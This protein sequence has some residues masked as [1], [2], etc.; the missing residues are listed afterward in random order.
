MAHAAHPDARWERGRHARRPRG[1]P[2]P[3][4]RDVLWRVKDR[5]S[6]DKLSMIAAGVAFYALMA[7]FPALIALVGVYGMLFDPNAVNQQI[8]TLSGF[9]P[10][11]AANLLAGQLGEITSMDRTSLGVGSIAAL[12]FALWSAS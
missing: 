4:W 7:I 8:T 11:E 12:L 3:G 9:L 6:A 10:E 2:A 1:I 5:V